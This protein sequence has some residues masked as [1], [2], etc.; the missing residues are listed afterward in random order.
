MAYPAPEWHPIVN[1]GVFMG[2]ERPTRLRLVLMLAISSPILGRSVR[3]AFV[4]GTTLNLINQWQ[5]ISH[6]FA[7]LDV[8]KLFF[9][10]LVPYLVATFSAV[11]TSLDS[12]GEDQSQ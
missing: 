9:N 7:R 11:N 12:R 2:W 3:I 1:G 5:A 6:G 10:F 4:V 8:P